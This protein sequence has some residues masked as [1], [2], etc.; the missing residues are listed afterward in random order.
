MREMKICKRGLYAQIIDEIGTVRACSWA[1]YYILGNLRDN[2]MSEV[3][4]SEAAKKFRHTL[5][6]GT[7]EFCNEENCP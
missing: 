3:F 6:D 7:Y 2:T 1:G 5:L 4:N